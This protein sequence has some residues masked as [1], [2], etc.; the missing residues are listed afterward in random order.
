M[1][2]IGCLIAPRPLLVVCGIYDPIFPVQ[3]V[4]KSFATI[5]KAYEHLG[6]GEMCHLLKGDGVHQQ[7]P[8]LLWPM[9]KRFI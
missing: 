7:F 6:K 1:G 2:D 8:E 9:A 4:E 3:G 5:K